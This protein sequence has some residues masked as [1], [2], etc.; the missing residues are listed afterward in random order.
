MDASSHQSRSSGSTSRGSPESA[1][2]STANEPNDV[3]SG[4]TGVVLGPVLLAGAVA[5]IYQVLTSWLGG[6]D[7]CGPP[8]NAPSAPVIE[9]VPFLLPFLAAWLRVPFGLNRHRRTRAIVFGVLL[10]IALATIAE[11]AIFVYNFGLHHCGE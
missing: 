2:R 11:A 8:A 4:P 5:V 1:Q 7:G 9:A 10:T 3:P 6:P